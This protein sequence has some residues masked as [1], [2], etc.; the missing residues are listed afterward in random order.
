LL[1]IRV[2]EYNDEIFGKRGVVRNDTIKTTK[3]KWVFF[4]DADMIFH[5]E[6]FADLWANHTRQ[7]E[8][9]GVVL[10]APRWSTDIPSAYDIIDNED[11]ELNKIENSFDKTNAITTGYSGNGRA[12]GAGY[13]Q[14]VE[15]KYMKENNIKYPYSNSERS[16]FNKRGNKFNSDIIFR[17]QFNK[18]FKISKSRRSNNNLDILPPIIHLNHWRKRNREWIDVCR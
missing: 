14:Y 11:Y 8:G 1:D 15:T 16:L 3:A 12:P 10:T 4:S 7:W 18:V 9:K 6:F 13:F 17:R 5:P 2:Q